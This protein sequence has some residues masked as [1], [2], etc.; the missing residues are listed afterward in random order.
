MNGSKELNAEEMLQR[1][2]Q[3][4]AEMD[5]NERTISSLQAEKE[6]LLT[7]IGQQKRQISQL[8]D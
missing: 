1:M 8:I 7:E 2:E 5:R 3:M 6:E 4:A